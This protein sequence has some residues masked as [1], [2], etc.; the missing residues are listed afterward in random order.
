VP[1]ARLAAARGDL[2]LACVMTPP[3]P[4]RLIAEIFEAVTEA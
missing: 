2:S 3:T 4:E 1:L